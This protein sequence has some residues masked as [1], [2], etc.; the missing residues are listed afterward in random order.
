MTSLQVLILI[1]SP[2]DAPVM[3]GAVDVLKEL[4]ISAEMTVAQRTSI[5]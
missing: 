2:N 4:G 1:G 3:Q 5:A